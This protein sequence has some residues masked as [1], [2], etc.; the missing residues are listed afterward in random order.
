MVNLLGWGSLALGCLLAILFHP[1]VYFGS[2]GSAGI[3]PLRDLYRA[4]HWLALALAAISLSAF[5][6]RG[7][8][9][10]GLAAAA[11]LCLYEIAGGLPVFA[12]GRSLW[13]AIVHA[14]SESAKRS[15]SAEVARG[16]A[17]AW[18]D[19]SGEVYR[20]AP[21][22]VDAPGCALTEPP[23]YAME[24]PGVL[25]GEAREWFRERGLETTRLP[26]VSFTCLD[27][28][29]SGYKISESEIWLV[30]WR[31][32]RARKVTLTRR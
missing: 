3:L 26:Y 4:G 22:R 20:F 25:A 1:R 17:G 7:R 15:A 5:A 12:G 29:V 23:G 21:D 9:T 14:R 18:A 2:T 19:A 10:P 30:D 27:R 8:R 24:P 13:G 31:G 28:M 16:F 32:G 11:V 6:S